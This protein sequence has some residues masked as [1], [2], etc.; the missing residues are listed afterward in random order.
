MMVA[1]HLDKIIEN[2]GIVKINKYVLLKMHNERIPR[3]LLR[4]ERANDH[5]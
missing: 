2:G 4:R 5:K 1:P 3:R